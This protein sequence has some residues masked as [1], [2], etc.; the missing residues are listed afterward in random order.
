M[1]DKIKN[2]LENN[3]L[4]RPFLW[5]SFIYYGE[6]NLASKKRASKEVVPMSQL[7]RRRVGIIDAWSASDGERTLRV[8][9]PLNENSVVFDMG[10]FEGNWAAEIYARYSCHILVF[11]PHLPFYENIKQRFSKNGKIKVYP[12]G[13]SSKT[14]KVCFYESADGSSTFQVTE[15]GVAEEKVTEIELVDVSDFIEKQ[16]VRNIDLIKINIEGGEFELL[17]R[18]IEKKQL[19]L[20]A[21]LQI[22]FHDIN[23]ESESRMRSIQ[24]E[25]AKTHELTYQFEFIWENWKRKTS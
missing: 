25:L 11:E 16:N 4:L 8:D 17:E 18:L 20:F 9:Y 15:E 24:N 14:E 21:N 23:A 6:G 3:I 22:Q 1:K 10:G 7:D 13:L 12:F 5:A 19:S 2:L